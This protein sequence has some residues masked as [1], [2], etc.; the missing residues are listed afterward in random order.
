MEANGLTRLYSQNKDSLPPVSAIKGQLGHT[1]GASGALEALV[2]VL[3]LKHGRIPGNTPVEQLDE[4]VRL[5]LV[6]ET[7][8][9]EMTN[10]LSVSFAFGGCN[11]ATLY[12]HV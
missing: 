11:V 12:S 5:N 4:G 2:C 10:V 9:S 6:T 3:A 1:L 7:M 8:S